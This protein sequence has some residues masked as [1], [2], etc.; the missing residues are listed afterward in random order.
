MDANPS[1]GNGRRNRTVQ[2]RTKVHSPKTNRWAKGNDNNRQ[3]LDRHAVPKSLRMRV[4]QMK[5]IK[6]NI[7]HALII[8]AITLTVCFSIMFFSVGCSSFVYSYK[9]Q[10]KEGKKEIKEKIAFHDVL[11]S[12]HREGVDIKTDRARIVIG[13]SS[14]TPD[15]NSIKAITEGI[16]EGVVK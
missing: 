8:R 1:K 10:D 2:N 3:F 11:V 4:K 5:R 7:S 15:S 9:H 13:K 6:L 14:S 12:S 16:V